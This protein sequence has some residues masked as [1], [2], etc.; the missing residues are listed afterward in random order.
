MSARRTS[1]AS[2]SPSSAALAA[3]ASEEPMPSSGRGLTSTVQPAAK[4][5][6]SGPVTIVPGPSPVASTASITHRPSGLP[7]HSASSFP[8]PKRLPRPAAST[9][10]ASSAMRMQRLV[11]ADDLGQYRD[12]QHAG[13][14]AVADHTDR[15]TD[16]LELVRRD[17]VL[18]E[19]F[20]PSAP[21]LEPA[22]RADVERGRRQRPLEDRRFPF[23]IVEQ[24]HDRGPPVG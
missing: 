13:L 10:T 3:M 18:G 23:V 22:L 11:G 24:Q 21:G 19:P 5:A 17:A 16:A 9:A 8:P 4:F 2:A 1:S 6:P 20:K 12:R 7:A 15:R 14:A